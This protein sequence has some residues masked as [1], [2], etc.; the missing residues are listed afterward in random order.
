[1]TESSQTEVLSSSVWDMAVREAP[2]VQGT[3]ERGDIKLYLVLANVVED[4]G[5]VILALICGKEEIVQMSSI[6]CSSQ[7]NQY[8]PCGSCLWVMT[9]GHQVV[10]EISHFLS[11]KRQNGNHPQDLP[12]RLRAAAETLPPA[13]WEGHASVSPRCVKDEKLSAHN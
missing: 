13:P 4:G 7:L 8:V 6:F 12:A 2:Y 11:G 9:T 1:M 10:S 5:G 3:P